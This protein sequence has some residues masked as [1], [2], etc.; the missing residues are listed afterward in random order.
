MFTIIKAT[1][2]VYGMSLDL[3]GFLAVYGTVFN[4]NPLSTNP[5]YSIGGP[6]RY[7]QNILGGAGL[8]GTPSGLSGT[9]NKYE[10]D[11]SPTRGDLYVTGNNFEVQRERFVDYW[12][13]LKEGI[14]APEQYSALSDFHKERF[15]GSKQENPYFF[16][17][18]FAGVLVSPAGYSFPPAMMSNHSEEFP[19]GTLSRENLATFFGI[20]G[21]SP[22]NFKVKQGHERIPENWYKRPIGNDFGITGFLVD[23]LEHAAE[24][25]EFL[26]VGGNTGEKDS[27]FGVDLEDL[28]GGVF[29]AA[30]LLKGNNLLCFS[31]QIIQAAAPDILGTMFKDVKK[32]MSPLTDQIQQLLGSKTC[33][34]LQ[35][36]NW[37]LL[38]EYPGY[39]ED[40]GTYKGLSKGT[41]S[42][43]T[44]GLGGIIG[45]L[46][47]TRKN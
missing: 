14:P 47:T 9:H 30:D 27:F 42:G 22:D 24:Y 28:T 16:Y 46:I 10:S 41:L 20:E 17:S 23:V 21:D 35:K 1:N 45:G 6:S 4:G 31:L 25:P 13:A 40:Y 33:P 3:G 11:V 19:D 38:K 7:S 2:E 36:V 8:L 34:Q 5:G 29:S 37:D 43:I 12:N 18:P 39:T 44:E 15:E 32:A 26:S